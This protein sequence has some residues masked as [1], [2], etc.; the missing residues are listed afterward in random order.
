MIRECLPMK[1]RIEYGGIRIDDDFGDIRNSEGASIHFK[2]RVNFFVLTDNPGFG[3]IPHEFIE[4]LSHYW[5][6]ND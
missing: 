6:F 1:E 2:M 5:M 4:H 3:V